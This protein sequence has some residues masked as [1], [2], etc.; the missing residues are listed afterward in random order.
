[1]SNIVN[2]ENIISADVLP[3]IS[4]PIG[5]QHPPMKTAAELLAR[6][7]NPINNP[8]TFAAKWITMWKIPDDIH[9][10]IP[11]LPFHFEINKD[12]QKPLED[13]LRKLI[14]LRLHVEIKT[15]DGCWVIR[16]QRGSASISRHAW[17]IALDLNQA[18][19]PLYGKTSWSQTFLNVWR[20]NG[21]VC[22][23]DFHSRKDAMHF[24]Y[25]SATAW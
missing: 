10:A 13:T 20:N 3:S 6:Y 18:D 14:S 24:E 22:G 15:Y 25:S 19:N 4:A 23:A 12:I 21:W 9:T 1:M 5:Y 7:G 17:G 11:H 8:K 2:D 16:N